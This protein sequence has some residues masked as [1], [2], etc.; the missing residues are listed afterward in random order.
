MINRLQFNV[1]MTDGTEHLEVTPTLADRLEFGK[2]ARRR[3]WPTLQD[4]PELYMA[5]IVWHALNREGKLG[6]LGWD[7]FVNGAETVEPVED[8]EDE[9][10]EV[11]PFRAG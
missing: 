2:V 1:L 4:D 11:E 10:G 6:G 5:F 8:D 7:E 9:A 3:K